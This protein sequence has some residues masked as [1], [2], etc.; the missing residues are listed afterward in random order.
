MSEKMSEMKK[1]EIAQLLTKAAIENGLII[2][3]G[4]P[5]ATG[6]NVSEFFNAVVASLLPKTKNDN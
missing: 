1:W 6:R 4:T 2:K 5:N 3:A